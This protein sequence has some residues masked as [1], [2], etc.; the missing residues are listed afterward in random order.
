MTVGGEVEL[1]KDG[2][3]WHCTSRW[4]AY[5][6]KETEVIGYDVAGRATMMV[7]GE[8]KKAALST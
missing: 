7:G 4:S 2:C 6:A 3:N 8:L 5:F 1:A